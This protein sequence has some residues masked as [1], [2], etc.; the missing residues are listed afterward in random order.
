MTNE[1]H[2]MQIE[3]A[4]ATLRDTAPVP[5]VD[6]AREQALFEAFEAHHARPR[7]SAR[8]ATWVWAAAAASMTITLGLGRIGIREAPSV[9]TTPDAPVDL[10]GFVPWPGAYALPPLESGELRR[11]DLPRAALPTLG[12]VAPVSAAAVVPAEVVIG[13]DGLARLVR[14]VRQQ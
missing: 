8:R 14:L 4:L 13:Q 6:P 7:P 12:L 3:D 2:E 10:A 11:V 9:E 5:P 1:R